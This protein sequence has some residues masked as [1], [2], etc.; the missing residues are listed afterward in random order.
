M[1]EEGGKRSAASTMTYTSRFAP[2]GSGGTM[3]DKDSVW[4]SY[5]ITTKVAASVYRAIDG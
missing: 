4:L 2:I 5:S 3:D 1:D